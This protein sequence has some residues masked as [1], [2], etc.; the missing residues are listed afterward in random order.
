VAESCEYGDE[1]SGS[2]ATEL[3]DIF[4]RRL[5]FFKEKFN[6]SYVKIWITFDRYKPNTNSQ[7]KPT[8]IPNVIEP[9]VIVSCVMPFL[10]AFIVSVSCI[11]LIY[12]L[13]NSLII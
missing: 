13:L 7:Y 12:Q 5:L 10:L 8:P 11:L 4:V 3:A 1:P 2:G 9:R 6:L